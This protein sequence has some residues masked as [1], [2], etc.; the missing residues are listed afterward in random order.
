MTSAQ[1]TTLERAIGH[2]SQDPTLNA[3]LQVGSL[4]QGSGTDESDID[5]VLVVREEEFNRRLSAHQCGWLTFEFNEPPVPY[6]EGKY[7]SVKYLEA[8][9]L[10]GSEPTRVHLSSAVL[11][12]GDLPNLPELVGRIGTYPESERSRNI[13]SFFAQ[14][15]VQSFFLRTAQSRNDSWLASHAAAKL[16]YFAYR[17]VLAHHRVLF[18]TPKRLLESYDAI[19]DRPKDLSAALERLRIGPTPDHGDQAVEIVRQHLN[20]PDEPLRCLAEFIH[21]T[22]MSWY[23]SE[24]PLEER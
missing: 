22:E 17:A 5:L 1:R 3:I 20:L 14:V 19:S 13:A 21:D 11:V 9:A 7:V 15:Q 2:F 12:W 10:R 18:A 23:F 6:C 4:A 24:P 8:A 16:T